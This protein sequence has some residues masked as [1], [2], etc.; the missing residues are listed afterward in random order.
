MKRLAISIAAL[1]LIALGIYRIA[2]AADYKQTVAD[3]TATYV[4][5]LEAA[6]QQ[7]LTADDAAT[8]RSIAAK[9]EA[10]AEE[11]AII[12]R[13]GWYRGVTTVNADGTCHWKGPNHEE[14]GV[15]RKADGY[16]FDWGEKDNDWNY[17]NVDAEGFLSGR[18]VKWGGDLKSEG[19][20]RED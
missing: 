5:V 9:I 13:W 19:Q 12:G 18:F 14:H 20:K 7:A 17:L 4:A 6:R 16:L 2:S 10:V 1:L 3:A 15:W 8:A 11:P